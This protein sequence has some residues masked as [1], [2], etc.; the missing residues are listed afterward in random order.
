[1]FI[2]YFIFILLLQLTDVPEAKRRYKLRPTLSAGRATFVCYTCGTETPSSNL[3]LVYCCQNSENEPFF[4]F[5]KSIKPYP[6]ASPISPQGKQTHTHT[7][8]LTQKK[9]KFIYNIQFLWNN[10]TGM[11][12]ICSECNSKH[13]N[14]AETMTDKHS[15]SGRSLTYGNGGRFSPSDS[16]SQANSDSSYVRFK[17]KKKLWWKTITPDIMNAIICCFYRFFSHTKQWRHTRCRVEIVI[18]EKI[19]DQI[20]HWLSQSERMGMDL[21]RKSTKLKPY[22]FC[23]PIFF[24]AISYNL[25][26]C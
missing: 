15:E 21:I 12:Q 4:P 2:I 18:Q 20:H 25:F 22:K 3:V 14:S 13:I 8:L 7:F 16:K 19:L 11:V 6:N 26:L 23:R 17:V 5:I 9:N 1:M 10:F 24:S